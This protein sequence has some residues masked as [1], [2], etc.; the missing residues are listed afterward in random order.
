MNYTCYWLTNTDLHH[1]A[2]HELIDHYALYG[3]FE[4]R[5]M[6]C[7]NLNIHEKKFMRLNENL[8]NGNIIEV[9]KI[10]NK[11]DSEDSFVP[12]ACYSMRYKDLRNFS[13]NEL[14]DHY[15][16]FGKNEERSR[17]CEGFNI[18]T[19]DKFRHSLITRKKVSTKSIFGVSNKFHGVVF[20]ALVSNAKCFRGIS[21]IDVYFHFNIEHIQNILE[22]TIGLFKKMVKLYPKASHYVKIDCDTYIKDQHALATFIKDRSPL[23]WGGCQ[24]TLNMLRIDGKPLSYAQGGIYSLSARVVKYVIAQAQIIDNSQA[25]GPG[26]NED[27]MIGAACKRLNISLTCAGW[28]VSNFGFSSTSI[29]YHPHLPKCNMKEYGGLTPKSIDLVITSCKGSCS[30]L[31]RQIHWFTTHNMIVHVYLFEKC[32]VNSHCLNLA[33]L[34]IASFRAIKISNVGRC[35]HT[36]AYFLQERYYS[37]SDIVFFVKDTLSS[38]NFPRT[39]KS[40]MLSIASLYGF[41][42]ATPLYKESLENMNRYLPKTYSSP[43]VHMHSSD[44]TPFLYSSWEDFLYQHNVSQRQQ[45]T[46]C[47]GGSYMVRPAL[48]HKY[49]KYFFQKISMSLSRG[50]NIVESHYME[51]LWADLFTDSYGIYTKKRKKMCTIAYNK[52]VFCSASDYI[53]VRGCI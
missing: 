11:I 50:N 32:G 27:A 41:S 28:I 21:T 15:E 33:N 37:L 39:P 42:C 34:A 35:D 5:P 38:W 48:I 14:R 8:Q 24:N 36:M 7:G 13:A 29:A 45:L 44:D 49:P 46:V 4:N 52:E 2:Y 43:S 47:Y 1:L 51:R 23:Y 16:Q 53:N 12:L 25:I 10:M 17:S 31:A 20:G 18:A 6:S 3:R 30:H 26:H 40:S 19:I 9:M 22:A